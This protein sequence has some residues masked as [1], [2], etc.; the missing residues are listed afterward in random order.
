MT[1]SSRIIGL[2]SRAVVEVAGPDWRSFLQGLLTNDVEGLAPGEAR[3]AALLT[4]QG[5]LVT[6]LAQAGAGGQ[7]VLAEPSGGGV[8][9]ARAEF[10]CAT[11]LLR[12]LQVKPAFTF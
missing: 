10:D 3:F 6:V 11:P 5:R 1:P 8:L 7:G 12:P 9:R 2:E 4:P